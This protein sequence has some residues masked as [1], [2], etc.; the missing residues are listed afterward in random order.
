MSNT[1]MMSAALVSS[2]FVLRIRD[3][4][5]SSGVSP[6]PFDER[7]HRDAGLE[8]GKAEGELRK[9]HRAT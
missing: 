4:N 6:S 7:H 8:S 9:E 2:L 3:C 1:L 5:T